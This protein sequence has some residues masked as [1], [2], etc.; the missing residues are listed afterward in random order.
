MPEPGPP[1]AGV[2]VVEL[3][4]SLDDRGSFTRLFDAERFTA[5]GRR[6]DFT[7][8]ARSQNRHAGTLRG[9]HWQADPYAEA[10][11]VW[12]SR[13]ALFD[14]AVDVRPGSP[15]RGAHVATELHADEP[16]AIYLAP[17]IAHGFQTLEDETDVS[18][19]LTGP[20]MPSAERGVRYDDPALG[21]A[22]PVADV[23]CSTRDRGLPRLDDVPSG[24]PEEA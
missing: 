5:L 6:A 21:I 18:Y 14:V 24:A 4:S 2:A 23:I 20:Y 13:G 7:I 19:L 17:G 1:I 11:L 10:K 3:A 9:L 12:C 16:L 8:A 22:W 15:T